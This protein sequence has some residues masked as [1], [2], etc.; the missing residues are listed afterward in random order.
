[1]SKK[2]LEYKGFQGSVEF[3][4]ENNILYGKILHIDDLIS[5]E[6]DSPAGLYDSFVES[7]E[8]YLETCVELG[9]EPNK[10]FSGTFNV[11]I[12]RDLHREAARNASREDKSL[13]DFVKDAIECHIHGRHQEVHH[14]YP[15]Q[16][17]YEGSFTVHERRTTQKVFLRVVK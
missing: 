9:V 6:A 16:V 4:L 14:H 11:R 3:S 17:D 10:P 2:I 8:D 5:F 13:N 15:E 1:M 7:V 12:G